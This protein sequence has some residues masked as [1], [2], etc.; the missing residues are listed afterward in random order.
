MYKLA[1]ILH[2][3][4]LKPESDNPYYCLKEYQNKQ[5]TLWIKL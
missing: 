1:Y 2:T 5:S 3:F 4:T